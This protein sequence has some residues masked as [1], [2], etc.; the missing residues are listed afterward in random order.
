MEVR[1]RAFQRQPPVGV[2]IQVFE[3]VFAFKI[4]WHFYFLAWILSNL[5]TMIYCVQLLLF[6]YSLSI[7]IATAD[8]FIVISDATLAPRQNG[9]VW[10]F[11]GLSTAKRRKWSGCV[12]ERARLNGWA[13]FRFVKRQ[14]SWQFV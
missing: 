7:L 4:F 6:F 10:V 2:V 12:S 8:T 13:L 9:H 3:I 11:M 5:L 14:C 1:S